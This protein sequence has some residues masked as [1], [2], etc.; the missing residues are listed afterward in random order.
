VIGQAK[1]VVGAEVQDCGAGLPDLPCRDVAGL[2]GVDAAFGFEESGGADVIQ[3][4]LQLVLDRG[5]HGAP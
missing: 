2:R 3:F 5:V 4:G 1:V